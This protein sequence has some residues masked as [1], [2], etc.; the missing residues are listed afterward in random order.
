V[1]L[2]PL[3]LAERVAAH[4]TTGAPHPTLFVALSGG[5]DSAALLHLLARGPLRGRVRALHCDH[6]L[7]PGSAAWA[8]RCAALCARLEVPLEVVRLEIDARSPSGVEAAARV[9]RYAALAA[10][11]GPGDLALTAHHA[12]DQAETF[13]LM[14]L[15]GSGVAG[16]AA[17]PEVAPLGQGRQLRPLLGV[18]R[19]ALAAYAL[20]HALDPVDDPS[21]A[22]LARDRNRIRHAVLPTLAPRWPD[23]ALALGRAAAW[24]GEATGLLA[25]LADEDLAGLV[26][27]EQP[28]R[29]AVGPLRQLSAPRVRNALRRWIG[30]LELPAPP[31]TALERVLAEVLPARR[32]AR[33]RVEWP[34]GWIAKHRE[35]VYA[36][37]PLVAFAPEALRWDGRQPL[38]VPSG[39]LLAL[40]PGV[41][42]CLALGHLGRRLEVRFRGGAEAIRPAGS[43]H[44][45]PLKKLLC[46]RGVLPWMRGRL[47]L[48]FVDGELAAVPGVCVAEGH[49][50][51]RG[52]PGLALVW[53]GHP[54]L[55]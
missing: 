35:H 24:C 45:R 50:S 54:P 2:D 36:G 15:R 51:P 25:E 33:A 30:H 16:L 28:H 23:A 22:D 46:E 20:R 3:V 11:L 41:D 10:R 17:M 9:A 27:A 44:H 42:G 12:D 39:G 1:I 48:L 37:A 14:A 34:G 13:L 32:D 26:E 38:P 43:A 19:A 21:N 55:H 8:E 29:L 47:P 7:Q 53:R 40:E 18:R 49:Q 52:A 31:A 6:G 4:A 5:A